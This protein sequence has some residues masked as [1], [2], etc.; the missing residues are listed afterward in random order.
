MRTLPPLPDWC[1]LEHRVA[2]ILTQQEIHG[3]TFNEQKAQ[4]LESHLRREMEELTE[5]LRKQW[6]LIGGAMFT[7]KRDN[8]TQ[9]YRAGAEFQRLKEFN[10]TS[11]DHIAWILTNRLNVKLSKTTTTG[12]PIIDEI[13]LTEIN[14]PFSLACAKCLTIKKKLGMISDGVNA[15]NRLVTANSRIHHHCSVSTNTFRCAH[16]K[17]NLGQVPADIEFR[18]LFTASPGMTMVGADLSGIEL[19][20]LAHYLGRYDGGRYADILLNDDIHQVN[21]DKIGITRRQVK[22]VTYA[23]LYGAGNEKIGT[24]YDN[25]LQPKEAKKKGSEIRKA[26]ISAIDGLADLLTAVTNKSTNGF[27]LAC[28]GRRVLVDSPHKGLNYLLQCGAG[29]VA[30]RWMVIANSAIH[31]PHTHQLAFVHDEL[32]YETEP[33]DAENLKNLLEKSAEMAGEFYN[34]RCPI[35]AEAKAGMT[36]ADVH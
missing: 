33:D 5:V 34:L 11:R 1:S 13:I 30:K 36:W 29:I 17:P 10:P 16:R 35:A 18:E 4:Q 15:W 26:F 22:T 32:Q 21:A 25:S 6:T 8:S 9:G 7:P 20:M 24:S 14:I 3:W 2:E 31:N 28:D 19:R 23:F 27:L 12:K